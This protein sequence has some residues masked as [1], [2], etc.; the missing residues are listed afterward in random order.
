MQN[1]QTKDLSKKLQI[2][3]DHLIDLL[4]D[5][6][7]LA[8][9][10]EVPVFIVGG[11]V[12]DML[13]GISNFDID[14]VIEGDAVAF[15]KSL[16]KIVNAKIK[17]FPKFKTAKLT[18]KN[19]LIVDLAMA[20]TESYACPAALPVVESSSLI[21]DLYR[22]DFTI[23]TLALS[24]NKKTFGLVIDYFK[25]SEDIKQKKIKILHDLSFIDD[26]TRIFR[27]V[28]FEQRF[29][30]RIDKHTLKLIFAAIDRK[31]FKKIS[32]FRMT[33]E[34]ILLL[35]EMSPLKVI[36][37]M[38]ALDKLDFMH[39]NIKLKLDL[40]GKIKNV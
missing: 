4:R 36:R 6:G 25:A 38:N 27:A 9:E 5:I 1:I 20:R 10:K 23:N 30:F 34:L 16:K 40:V 19:G 31:I 7:K 15:S 26:P 21:K 17:I 32:R 37:R 14:L 28:R 11:F 13:I 12:R 22:R 2:L 35:S 24:L 18:L 29:D 3:P 8:D 39:P 33:N